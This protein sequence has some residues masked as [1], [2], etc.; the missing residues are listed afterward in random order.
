VLT[1]GAREAGFTN[2]AGLDGTVRFLSNRAGMWVLEE[3][4]REWAAQGN[5]LSHDVLLR[6]ADLRVARRGIVDLNAPAVRRA[7]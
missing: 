2:E 5:A 6:A 4:R 7:R 3:C 1:R